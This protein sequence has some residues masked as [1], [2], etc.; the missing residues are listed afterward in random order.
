MYNYGPPHTKRANLCDSFS[1]PNTILLKRKKMGNYITHTYTL[2]TQKQNVF[3][4]NTLVMT[5]PSEVT[6]F[7]VSHN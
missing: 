3:A 6:A 1:Q 2:I 4:L 5:I 7:S